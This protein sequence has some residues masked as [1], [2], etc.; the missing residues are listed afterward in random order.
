MLQSI[1]GIIWEAELDDLHFTFVSNYTKD[2]LG[3]SPEEWL[4]QPHFWEN[5]IHPDDRTEVLAYYRLQSIESNHYSFEFR[6]LKADGFPVWI[7]DSVS[8]IKAKGEK[9]LLRG[10][11]TDI[12]KAKQ[13]SEL[14]HLEKNIL[15]LYSK[16]EKSFTDVL[17]CYLKGVERLFPQIKCSILKVKNNRLYNWVSPSLPKPYLQ[18]IENLPIGENTGSCGTSAFLKQIVIVNDIANDPKWALYKDL[19]LV[20]KLRACWSQTIINS[21]GV[22]MAT[23]GMYYEEVK[24]PNENEL[25][26]IERVSTLLQIILENRLKSEIIIENS[27]LITQSQELAGFGN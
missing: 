13:L 14:E 11:M 20:H 25:N 5:H 23:L 18:A 3:Y 24:S 15:E 26:V 16:N 12:T 10:L 17:S 6:M 8:V 19:T 4:E 2:I 21:D 27:L 22:V 7:K 9:T 1:E